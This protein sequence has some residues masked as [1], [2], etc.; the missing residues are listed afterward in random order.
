MFFQPL[1]IVGSSDSL[2][3]MCRFTGLKNIILVYSALSSYQKQQVYRQTWAFPSV[4]I[5]WAT[6][7]TVSEQQLA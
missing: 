3:Y 6:K 5:G 4:R 7:I 1:Y 2:S